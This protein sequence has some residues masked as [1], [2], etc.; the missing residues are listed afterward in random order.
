MRRL[1]LVFVVSAVGALGL[2][3]C[4]ASTDHPS[5]QTTA[6]SADG[7]GEYIIP[8]SDRV[9]TGHATSV[10]RYPNGRE[11]DETS[12]TGAGEPDPCSLVPQTKAR[13]IL[14]ES[15]QT[16]VGAQG[17][18]CIYSPADAE[19]TI[20]VVIERASLAALRR[21]ASSARPVAVGSRSGWCL[22]YGST[23]VAVPLSAGSVL[24]VTGP[25]PLAARFAAQALG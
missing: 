7:A 5:P 11:N 18:T 21:G 9:T 10:A 4:G 6:Q 22:R 15:V 1:G 20:T 24:H 13:A 3:A 19:R 23:S 2:S 8:A 17:P 14:D 16:T 12:E 25:C